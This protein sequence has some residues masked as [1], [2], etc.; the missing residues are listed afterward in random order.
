MQQLKQYY[1]DSIIPALKKEFSIDTVYAVPQ[2]RKIVI[3]VGITQPVD[4]KAR[5]KVAENVVEQIKVI[6]GQQPQITTAK[7]SI[8]GFKLR[9]GDPLGVMVTLRGQFM[10][11]FLQKLLSVALP[12]VKDFRGVSAKA[13]D[14][15]GNFSLGIDEQIIFPEINYDQIDTVRGLQINFV[16]TTKDDAQAYKLLELLGMP[17]EKEEGR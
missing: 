5:R 11:D 12:R 2:L 10:W 8:A 3:N 15:Q 6:S 17:F 16:T 7:K 14:H 1:Q 13:F 4:P 9:A